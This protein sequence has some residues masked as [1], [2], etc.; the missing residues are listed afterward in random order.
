MNNWIFKK[1]LNLPTGI[2][3]HQIVDKIKENS[4]QNINLDQFLE[5]ILQIIFKFANNPWATQKE[6]ATELNISKE[7]LLYLN[8]FI[9]ENQYIQN[10]IIKEGAG[11]KYWQSISPFCRNLESSINNKFSYPMRIAFYPGVSC[12]YY[13][14]FCGRNQEAR[15][16]LN[17]VDSGLDMYKSVISEL[18][19][20]NTAISISGGLEPLTN[21]KL[22]EI[23]EFAANHG[24]RVPLITNGHSLTENN[25]K[26][27]QGLKKLDS[28]RISLYGVDEKS[29]EFI[30]TIKKSYKTV[31]RNC[32]NFLKFR[33]N[34]NPNIKFG[35]N[36]IILKENI[37]DLPKLINFISEV[38]SEVDNGQGINF[39]SL[40]DD[41]DTVTGISDKSDS[42]RKYHLSGLLNNKDRE[43]LTR[44]FSELEK[45]SVINNL[46]VDYGYAL[47]SIRNGVINNHL[48][49]VNDSEMRKFG[50]TQMSVAIDLFGDVFL[51]REAGFL[52]RKGNE[53]FIIGRINEKNSL[54]SVIKKFLENSSGVNSNLNDVRFMD[55][56]DHVLTSLINQAEKDHKF[57]IP[58]EDGPV[59]IRSNPNK[60]N[61]GNNWYKNA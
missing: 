61:L 21:L 9:R 51:Y 33:N 47:H 14:G 38:N 30:T 48:K 24:L 59:L 27:N 1:D 29:Y 8:K 41:F 53:K 26:R 7:K 13:C 3:L 17:A 55:P 60:I 34:I 50:H 54:K 58:F 28:I 46:H 16:P 52:N 19:P 11:Y 2:D 18:D 10:L 5:P 35:L 32:I 15:Y 44:I 49:K 42:K 36:Y 25:I 39:L 37:D 56:F 43:K 31:K 12:M 20:E 40:R 4:Q 23:I 45:S 6:V 22:G 57:G